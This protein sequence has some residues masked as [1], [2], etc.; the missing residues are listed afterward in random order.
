LNTDL[1]SPVE[2]LM[3][4]ANSGE[5][6]Q[7]DKPS[8]YAIFERRLSDWEVFERA[9]VSEKPHWFKDLLAHWR[10]SGHGSGKDGLRLAIRDGYLNFYRLGQSIARVQSVSGDLIADVHYKYVLDGR[11]SGMS[12]KSPYLRLTS[13]GVSFKATKVAGYEGLATLHKWIA[14]AC[15][16]KGDEKPIVDELVEKNDHV[17][18]LEM[19]I[20]A[21]DLSKVAVRMDLVAIENGMVV[22]WEAK[23]VNDG[24]IRCRAE[25]EADK[26]PH[27]LEQLSKYRFFLERDKHVQQVECAYRNTA[28]LLVAMR[29]L[30]DK[31]GPRLALG[32]S[33]LAASKA[34]RLCVA[35]EAALVVVDLPKD[36]GRAWRSWK[37]SHERKLQGKIP[38]R[39][40]KTAEP[41]IY[42]GAK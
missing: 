9:V 4:T 16:Y 34:D 15:D 7:F 2:V 22:F 39:V 41:L 13:E 11:P 27:V 30:A 40:L 23:T 42:A 29:A 3:E 19:A 5:A 17:I 10:P 31:I 20:P 1:D 25:F 26:S 33:I 38:M 35:R 24:R 21:W 12:E 14:A 36:G 18:D 28:K 37:A 6:C 32:P 8:H